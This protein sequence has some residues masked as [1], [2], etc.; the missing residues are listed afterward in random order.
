MRPKPSRSS[1]RRTP[2]I[3]HNESMRLVHT[4]AAEAAFAQPLTEELLLDAG[5][6]PGMRVLV[7]G[8][9]TDLALLVAERVGA[10]GAVLGLHRDRGC[11]EEARQRAGDEGF[12]SVGFRVGSLD[13]IGVATPFDA[14]VGRFFLT[15]ERDPV[16]AIGLAANAVHDG[17]RIIFHEWH[18]DSIRW[19]QTADWPHVEL[20]RQFAR[21]STEA[22]QH[23]ETHLDIGLRL[24][25]LFAEAG[26]QPPI[27]HTALRLVRGAGS[28]GYAF[29]EA[30]LRELW[31]TIERFGLA[32]VGAVQLDAFAERLEAETTAAGGHLFLPL[33]VGAWT[34]VGPESRVGYS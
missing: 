19:P 10:G 9:L 22:L 33:Q 28:L 13:E 20:Y 26:L 6:T 12:E 15:Y 11:V 34:S 25:N 5:I 30:K 17:G 27:L 24:A 8:D 31:P 7:L 16:R 32:T 18:Y 14:V 1:W 23:R 21:W 29:F 3:F 2:T 4:Q